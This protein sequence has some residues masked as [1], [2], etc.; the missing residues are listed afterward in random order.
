[1]IEKWENYACSIESFSSKLAMVAF[2][3]R[4]YWIRARWNVSLMGTC[5]T[6]GCVL[7][8]KITSFQKEVLDTSSESGAK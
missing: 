5:F 2:I 7:S 4:Q 8:G 6:H 1:M 3:G